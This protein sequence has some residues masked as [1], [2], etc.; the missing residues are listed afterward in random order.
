MWETPMIHNLF[1][2]ACSNW[3]EIDTVM[4][5][6]LAFPQSLDAVGHLYILI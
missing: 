5:F 2:K 6:D 4:E 1:D 3:G